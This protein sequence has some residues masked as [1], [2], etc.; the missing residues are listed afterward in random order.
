MTVAVSMPECVYRGS[1]SMREGTV[2][3]SLT[4]NGVTDAGAT[5]VL[6]ENDQQRT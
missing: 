3:V 6:I 2:S 5:L 4:L 1:D